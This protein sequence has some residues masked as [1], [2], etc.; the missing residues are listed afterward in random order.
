VREALAEGGTRVLQPIRHVSIEV[1][2]VY[3]GTLV[4]LISSLHGQVLGFRNNPDATG[5]DTFEAL[6]PESAESELFQVLGSATRGT[7]WYR[8][9]LE[10]YEEMH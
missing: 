5:W 1:P 2:S 6:L 10:R 4:P 8:S 3:A 7:A 9:Q